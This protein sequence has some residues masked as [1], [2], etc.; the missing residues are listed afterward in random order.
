MNTVGPA[1]ARIVLLT[2]GAL[3]GMLLANWYDKA[4]TERGQ[5]QF[6]YDKVRYEQGLTPLS[7]QPIIIEKDQ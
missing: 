4:R 6:D 2:G 5:E 3:I 1:L 7:P